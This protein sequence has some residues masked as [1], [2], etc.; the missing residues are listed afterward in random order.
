VAGA[1]AAFSSM[2]RSSVYQLY[3][4]SMIAQL[5]PI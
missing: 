3:S 1:G 5:S 2:A 4:D